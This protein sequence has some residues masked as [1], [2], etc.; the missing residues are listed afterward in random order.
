MANTQLCNCCE[1]LISTLCTHPCSPS[2]WVKQ[3]SPYDTAAN[4][5]LC[6]L[7]IEVDC[8]RHFLGSRFP[9][10]F[11]VFF[12][13]A[14][15]HDG[16]GPIACVGFGDE[17]KEDR[18]RFSVWAE[19]GNEPTRDLGIS[20]EPPIFTNDPHEAIPLIKKWLSE[21]HE[22]HDGCSKTLDGQGIS[23][24]ECV[25]LPTRVLSVKDLDDIKLVETRG[26]RGRYCALS[27][28][29]GSEDAQ[30]LRTVKENLND[31]LK[32]I[33]FSQLPKTFQE[34]SIIAH[35][36]GVDYLWIDAL[37]II[38]GD[39]N[40]LSREIDIMGS[41]YEKAFLSIFVSG[42]S[43]P[44]GGCFVVDRPADSLGATIPVKINNEDTI[45]LRLWLM[46]QEEANPG[47]GPLG[48]RGWALQERYLSRRKVFFMPG[49]I[50]WA[51]KTFDTVM[52]NERSIITNFEICEHDHW[53]GFLEEYARSKLTKFKDRLRAIRGIVTEM[54]KAGKGRYFFGVWDTDLVRQCLWMSA[55]DTAFDE[56]EVIPDIPS[57]S[58]ARTSG[59]KIWPIGENPTPGV[60]VHFHDDEG[61][62]LAASGLLRT[63]DQSTRVNDC[64]V[65]KFINRFPLNNSDFTFEEHR[66]ITKSSGGHRR[67]H[68]FQDRNG[69]VLGFGI[70]DS[71]TTSDCAFACWAPVNRGDV[72]PWNHWR[73]TPD[74]SPGSD[75]SD[76]AS[77][78]DSAGCVDS[79]ESC[80]KRCDQDDC[81]DIAGTMKQVIYHGLLLESVDDDMTSFTRVGMA[82]MY[83]PALEN[84]PVRDYKII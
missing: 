32:G 65:M 67:P 71:Q 24:E 57:W 63:I 35:G 20:T 36:L 56:N 49:G 2:E 74:K 45:R 41:I 25:M 79:T 58:W 9:R 11:D 44:T 48:S 37:C 7:L 60:R 27:Y 82:F 29:W 81:V 51:C 62:V 43:D 21:C 5:K 78:T 42:S 39:D 13:K 70:F 80:I 26:S 31:H 53:P 15:A 18:T 34:A 14:H 83:S 69:Q 16:T 84:E 33:R 19:N 59:A 75:I 6:Q 30:N 52:L 22:F 61:K 64:C 38:Q 76:D 1:K 47:H 73:E 72:G 68:V 3:R 23:K 66:L 17:G 10:R 4:C 77:D 28:C 8:T 50:S 55:I 46:S 12:R 54:V 40:D